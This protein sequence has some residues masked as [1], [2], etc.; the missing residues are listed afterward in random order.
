MRNV[1]DNVRVNNTFTH[2][3]NGHLQGDKIP[4]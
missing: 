3:T 2:L 4:C 1:I